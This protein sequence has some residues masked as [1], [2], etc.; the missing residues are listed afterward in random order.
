MST[1]TTTGLNEMAMALLEKR[2]LTERVELATALYLTAHLEAGDIELA[3]R[4]HGLSA[5]GPA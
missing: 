5:L 4:A 3:K 1:V 2:N